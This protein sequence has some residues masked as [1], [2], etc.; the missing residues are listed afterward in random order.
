MKELRNLVRR[1][2]GQIHLQQLQSVA[3]AV[4]KG[5]EQ[6]PDGGL[7]GDIANVFGLFANAGVMI[8]FMA[9]SLFGAAVVSKLQS[10]RFDLKRELSFC[11]KRI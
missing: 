8:F 9:W 1:R 5:H 2:V 3:T 4:I 6:F 11:R 10:R 7:A